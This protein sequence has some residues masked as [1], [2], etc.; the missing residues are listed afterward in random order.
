MDGNEKIVF[1]MGD[2]LPTIYDVVTHFVTHFVD[3]HF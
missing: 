3:H 2:K 1:V